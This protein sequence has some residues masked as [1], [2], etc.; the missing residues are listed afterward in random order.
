VTVA[1]VVM[2]DVVL[3]AEIRTAALEQATAHQKAAV[4]LEQARAETAALRTMANAAK[5]LDDHLTLAR[6]R[7]V[8]AAGPGSRMV[9][10]LSDGPAAE[11][12]S[13]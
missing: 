9:L 13:E 6:S 10:Q 7:L 1:D 2:K 11:A 5:L 4:Q 3:P 12:L 8:Q